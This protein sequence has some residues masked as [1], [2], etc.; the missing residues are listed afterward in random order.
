MKATI[1]ILGLCFTGWGA[2]GQEIDQ[3]RLLAGNYQPQP[4]E[5][6]LTTLT[7]INSIAASQQVEYKAGESV[8]LKP[9]F[10][11]KAGSIFTAHTGTVS[12][13]TVEELNGLTIRVYPNPFEQIT[14]ITYVLTKPAL[15]RLHICDG[16]GRLVS[17]L[18]DNLY[19]EK[20]RYSVE[21]KGGGV[22]GGSYLCILDTGSKRLSQRIVR[23]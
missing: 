20:G 21:W 10:E 6:A 4:L 9:G 14:T 22:S 23:K 11:A 16:E 12:L 3:T 5:Q 7:A 2:T 15:T 1:L 8:V 18:V 13:N 17:Q 19:Q